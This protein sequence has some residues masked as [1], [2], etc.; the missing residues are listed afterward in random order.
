MSTVDEDYTFSSFLAPP[1]FQDTSI[2][3]VGSSFFGTSNLLLNEPLEG[4]NG[5]SS[6]S[7]SFFS[8]SPSSV[9]LRRGMS[10]EWGRELE[11][12]VQMLAQPPPATTTSRD[13]SS[14]NNNNSNNSIGYNS[15]SGSGIIGSTRLSSWL[16][17]DKE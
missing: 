3:T 15:N 17:R 1:F 5:S 11:Q 8:S 13:I 9:G 16:N 12:E 6:S 2:T 10:E 4:L 7:S 14:S